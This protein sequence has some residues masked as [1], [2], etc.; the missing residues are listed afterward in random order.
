MASS[1]DIK[2]HNDT[3]QIGSPQNSD[4]DD[5]N[6]DEDSEQENNE[7]EKMDFQENRIG[8]VV[9]QSTVPNSQAEEKLSTRLLT[10]FANVLKVKIFLL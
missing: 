6:E 7:D 4:N 9:K 10:R 1:W 2:K 3:D 8:V 5:I